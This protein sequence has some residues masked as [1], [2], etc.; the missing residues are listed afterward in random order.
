MTRIFRYILAVD[1]GIAPCS[2][3]RL[4]TL[5]TCK[6]KIRAAARL[7]DWVVGFYPSPHPRGLVAWA[8]RVANILDFGK[9]EEMFRGRPDAV[10]RRESQGKF[11]RLRPDFHPSVAEMERDLSAPVLVFEPEQSWYFGDYP[12]GLPNHLMHLAAQGQGHRVNGATNSDPAALQ[13]W[14]L[15]RPPG[16][17]GSPR[18]RYRQPTCGT[19]LNTMVVASAQACRK[20]KKIPDRTTLRGASC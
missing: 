17:H 19:D 20:T 6:P 4:I 14:L 9:Y 11:W 16:T 5:A 18:D 3:A 13:N 12:R 7:H 8:G 1:S 10:Y 2:A 15:E